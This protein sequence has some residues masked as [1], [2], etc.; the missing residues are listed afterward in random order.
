MPLTPPQDGSRK[1]SSSSCAVVVVIVVKEV[2]VVKI[3]KVIG[4]IIVEIFG[5]LGFMAYQ[6][7]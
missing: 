7:F 1:S 3:G 4:K 5:W 6:S 2:I